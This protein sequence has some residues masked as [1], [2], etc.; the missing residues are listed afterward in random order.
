MNMHKSQRL[1][2]ATQEVYA[3]LQAAGIEVLFDDRRERPGAM[4]ANSELIGI[5]HRLVVGERGLDKGEIEYK[6]R[7]DQKAQYVPIDNVIEFI[8]DKLH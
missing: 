4:F 6:G 8:K 1:R 7:R 2:E 5:P 3:K